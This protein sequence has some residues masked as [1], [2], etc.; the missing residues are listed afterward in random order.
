CAP[1]P[2]EAGSGPT[3]APKGG[4]PVCWDPGQGW[5]ATAIHERD[6][7]PVGGRVSGPAVIEA[8]DTATVVPA[9]WQAAVDRYGNLV[10]EQTRLEEISILSVG[11]RPTLSMPG[12]ER[13]S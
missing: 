4:R 9:G 5:I 6:D 11:R 12:S 2:R 7:L 1:P 10:V 3:P 8:P 13:R